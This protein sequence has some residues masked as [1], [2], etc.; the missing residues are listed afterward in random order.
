[1]KIDVIVTSH[2]RPDMLERCLRSLRDQSQPVHRIVLCNDC[3]GQDVRQVAIANL[4]NQD[5]FVS[6]PH[7]KGPSETRNLGIEL[8]DGDWF[9]FLDDDDTLA[10]DYIEQA[11]RLLPDCSDCV[12]YCN[13]H[14]IKENADG[15]ERRVQRRGLARHD[16]SRIELINFIPV[17]AY[18]VPQALRHVR[19]DST[20]LRLEDWDYLLSLSRH[21]PLRHIRMQGFRYHQRDQIKT[22]NMIDG[23]ARLESIRRI[24]QKHRLEEEATERE[25]ALRLVRIARSDR[26]RAAELAAERS[27][28]RNTT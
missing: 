14:V 13:Y 24:Y 23:G 9:A 10:P 20:L 11:L 17:G 12:P 25:R 27:C 7:L 18:F 6:V 15:T 8:S 16:V 19:F 5:I 21:L 28:Q 22:R 3:G 4:R 2:R 1:M 26:R